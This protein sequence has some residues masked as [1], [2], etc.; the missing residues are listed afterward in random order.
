MR[1]ALMA[2]IVPTEWGKST[3]VHGVTVYEMLAKPLMHHGGED[4][5]RTLC[6]QTVT[7]IFYTYAHNASLAACDRYPVSTIHP[8]RVSSSILSPAYASIIGYSAVA[9]GVRG[10]V[11]DTFQG[12]SLATPSSRFVIASM[13]SGGVRL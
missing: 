7:M 5:Q 6:A 4:E 8:S 11:V 1:T 10:Y 12:P 9:R 2:S 3:L 13:A